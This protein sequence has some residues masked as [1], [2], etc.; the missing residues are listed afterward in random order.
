MSL[1]EVFICINGLDECLPKRRKLLESR[2]DI[3]RASPTTRV[4]LS[5]RT[6]IRDEVERYFA[7]VIMIP[8]IPTMEILGDI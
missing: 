5:G 6:H 8:I 4:L 3:V 7:A 2:R 1:A